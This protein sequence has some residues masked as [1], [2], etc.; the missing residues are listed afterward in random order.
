MKICWR[1]ALFLAGVGLLFLSW[2]KM[3]S[4]IANLQ[5]SGSAST[6]GTS[7]ILVVMGGFLALMAFAP[8]PQTL[9]GWMA[10]KQPKK[11]QPAHF[12]RRRQRG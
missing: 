6:V 12:K 2:H 10:L 1:V 3:H 11:A 4:E 5:S 7:Q 8:S 9:G